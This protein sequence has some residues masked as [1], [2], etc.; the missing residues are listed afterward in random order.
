MFCAASSSRSNASIV[1]N[2]LKTSTRWPPSIASSSNS[3][4]KSDFAGRR[5]GFAGLA[6]LEQAQVAANLAQAQQRGQHD[7]PAFG[8]A[9][10]CR[11]HR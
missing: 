2:W 7:H 5:R 4:N 9:A 10:A 3:R 11:R 8:Q 6:S 1:V